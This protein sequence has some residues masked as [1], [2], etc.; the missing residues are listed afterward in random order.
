MDYCM[1]AQLRG[2][3]FFAHIGG[4][5]GLAVAARHTLAWLLSQ[6][7][8]VCLR[9]ANTGDPRFRVDHTYDTLVT[10]WPWGLPYDVSIVHL[11]MDFT[12][13]DN[14]CLV[15]YDMVRVQATLTP[16]T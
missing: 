1:S 6:R 8:P 15:D 4:N 12:N 16:R 14:A 5:L 13:L 7:Q 10:H 3:N 9:D 11:N 2:F